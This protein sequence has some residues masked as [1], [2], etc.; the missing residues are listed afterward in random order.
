MQL[1]D[2]KTSMEYIK[3]LLLQQ[4]NPKSPSVEGDNSVNQRDDFSEEEEQVLYV[5]NFQQT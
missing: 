3:K 2:I 5:K 1:A 4:H